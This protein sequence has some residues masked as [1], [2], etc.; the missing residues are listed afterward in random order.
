MFQGPHLPDCYISSAT[1]R[2]E[3]DG[4]WNL[5]EFA[6]Y[7]CISDQDSTTPRPCLQKLSVFSWAIVHITQQCSKW[8]LIAFDRQKAIFQVMFGLSVAFDVTGHQLLLLRLATIIRL[9]RSALSWVRSYL[10]NRTQFIYI[11]SAW[12][13]TF[14]LTRGV[15]LD[16]VTSKVWWTDGHT[17]LHQW[18]HTCGHT[19]ACALFRITSAQKVKAETNCRAQLL[20]WGTQ[21]RNTNKHKKAWMRQHGPWKALTQSYCLN[22]SEYSLYYAI[23]SHMLSWQTSESPHLIHLWDIVIKW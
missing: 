12:S 9:D 17:H 4:C 5:T 6:T 16:S 22:W 23:V 1:L 21:L 7:L 18:T 14:D 3:L 20:R 10:L 13:S 2:W 19:H 15:P 11:S 8:Y